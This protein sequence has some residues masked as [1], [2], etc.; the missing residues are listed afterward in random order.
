MIRD[1]ERIRDK[2]SYYK[3]LDQSVHL[4]L[5]SRAFRNGKTIL[6]RDNSII[7]NDDKLG[8]IIIFLDEIQ[9]VEKR[10]EAI[11]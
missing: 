7:F 6:F 9:F 10:V 8:E 5:Y 4:T 11:R 3:E 1:E 2:L